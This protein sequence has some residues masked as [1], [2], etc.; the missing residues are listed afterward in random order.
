MSDYKYDYL[1]ADQFE[2]TA[3]FGMLAAG[4]ARA[5]PLLARAGTAIASRAAPALARAGTA[6]AERAAP[7]VARAGQSFAQRAAPAAGQA[8]QGI[9][10]RIMQYGRN[11]GGAMKTEGFGGTAKNLAKGMF[12]FGPAE[13]AS[14]GAKMI[15]GAGQAA[16]TAQ[17]V[18]GLGSAV[19][20]G[21]G[22][23]GG[24]NKTNSLREKQA[25][26]TFK[27]ASH[28]PLQKALHLSPYAAWMGSQLLEDKHP[29]L[30]K[31]LNLG[32]Y[33]LYAGMAGH[34]A[35]TNPN[36]RLTSGTDAL[37]LTAMGIADLARMRRN[38]QNSTAEGH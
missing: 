36:E 33:A 11:L 34:E 16:G 6:I 10:G 15:H 17:G 29:T 9:G 35:L 14:A 7:A 21:S 1:L 22:D 3:I 37:A 19:F 25:R 13:G 12:G 18:Y 31:G 27:G 23:S 28:S 38:S 2:K 24:Q 20:G 8:A 5:A 32:A 30:A 26:Y 4:A